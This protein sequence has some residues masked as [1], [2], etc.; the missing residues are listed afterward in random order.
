M[1]ATYNQVRL[2]KLVCT[3]RLVCVATFARMPAEGIVRVRYVL[4]GSGRNGSAAKPGCW[5]TNRT[6]VIYP[7]PDRVRSPLQGYL[8]LTNQAWCL[9]WHKP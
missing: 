2:T 5:Y 7:P 9:S 1:K 6:D 4:S 8:P 3:R